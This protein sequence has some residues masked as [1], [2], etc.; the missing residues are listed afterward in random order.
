MSHHQLLRLMA[1]YHPWAY[2]R[3]FEAVDRMAET[4]YRHDFG[5]AFRSVHGTL[6]HLL[7]VEHLWRERLQ[8]VPSS[9]TRLD[10]EMQH[11]RGLLRESL[12]QFALEWQTLVD[13]IDGIDKPELGQLLAYQNL[14]GIDL[15]LPLAPLILHVFNHATHHRGQ[16]TAVLTRLGFPAPEMDLP[17]F[18][19]ERPDI[20]SPG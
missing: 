1:E 3:L 20:A 8:Q 9:A 5:L 19:L 14:Q 10:Q 4:D 18:M 6:N 2:G 12:S 7:V 17:Y 13:E 11:D 16:I 15:E